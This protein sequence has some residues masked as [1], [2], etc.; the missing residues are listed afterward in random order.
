MQIDMALEGEVDILLICEQYFHNVTD[1]TQ[2][3][4]WQVR[5]LF[6]DEIDQIN[7]V[8]QKQRNG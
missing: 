3:L 5:G 4:F 7:S 2:W 8:L 6:S 1:F